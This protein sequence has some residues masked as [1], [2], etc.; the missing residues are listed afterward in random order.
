MRIDENDHIYIPC[1]ICGKDERYGP[2]LYK[3]HHLHLYGGVFCCDNC[4]K[5]NW[6]G[7]GPLHEHKLLKILESENLPIPD[8]N[9][10]GWLPRD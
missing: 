8:R 10:K 9:S 6:D 7:W 1:S 5:G 2:D 4:W 3:G